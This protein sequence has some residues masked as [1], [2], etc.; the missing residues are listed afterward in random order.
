LNAAYFGWQIT[1]DKPLEKDKVANFQYGQPLVLMSEKKHI[2]M[3]DKSSLKQKIVKQPAIVDKVQASAPIPV[4]VV[5]PGVK[6]A[7]SPEVPGAPP[8]NACYAVGPFLLVTDVSRAARSFEKAGIE[9]QQR[10]AAERKQVGFWVYIPP[11]ESLSDARNAL[12]TL[13]NKEVYDALLIAEGAKANS[14]SAG[15]YHSRAL[16]DERKN[17]IEA[18]G[19]VV[20][21]DPLYR[22]QPQYW[23]DLEIKKGGAIPEKLWGQVSSDFPS[24]SQKQNDCH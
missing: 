11:L 20:A 8:P 3:L 7:P 15:V 21:I 9:A 4:P 23:L 1:S 14:I 16:A 10:A 24:V 12:R 19:F 6:L 18:M 2:V 22:T 17:K 5:K 13:K